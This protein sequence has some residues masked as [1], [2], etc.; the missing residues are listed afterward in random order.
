M[1]P[2]PLCPITLPYLWVMNRSCFIMKWGAVGGIFSWK[3]A[4]LYLVA[5]SRPWRAHLNRALLF[6]GAPPQRSWVLLVAM[7]DVRRWWVGAGGQNARRQRVCVAKRTTF[8]K[9]TP[10]AEVLICLCSCFFFFLS[11]FGFFIS[12]FWGRW[13]FG[14]ICNTVA[15]ALCLYTWLPPS[16]ASR[17]SRLWPPSGS[18]GARPL[19]SQLWLRRCARQIFHSPAVHLRNTGHCSLC[20]FYA[21]SG[22]WARSRDH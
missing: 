2:L 4:L 15:Q 5:C 10:F 8:R 14:N 13:V 19:K 22:T 12:V 17:P 7:E 1:S 16:S 3:L 21:W 20:P 9:C 11:S 18:R 6:P